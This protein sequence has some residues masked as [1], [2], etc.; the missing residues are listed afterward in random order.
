LDSPDIRAGM[1]LV[2]A[3]LAAEGQ[4]VIRNV[5]QIDRG[6]ERIDDKLR[7]LGACIERTSDS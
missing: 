4:S 1:A 2:L 5:G 3:S 7:S 6:Y